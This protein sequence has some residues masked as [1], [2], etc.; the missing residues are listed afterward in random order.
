MTGRGA[1]ALALGLAL[2][3]PPALAQQD[4]RLQWR[5]LET[6]H[7]RIHFYQAMEPLARRVAARR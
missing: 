5:T 2:A 6:P 4:P 1:L 3:S 7:F